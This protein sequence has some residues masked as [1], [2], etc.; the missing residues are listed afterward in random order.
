MI[1]KIPYGKSTIDKN[2]SKYLSRIIKNG[3]LTSG[4]EV[5]KFENNFKK[6]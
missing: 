4:P 1:T 5:L 2:D 6:K 3:Y